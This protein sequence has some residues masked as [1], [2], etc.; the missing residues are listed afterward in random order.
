MPAIPDPEETIA[1]A[2]GEGMVAPGSPSITGS[3]TGEPSTL[4]HRYE[5]AADPNLEHFQD[6]AG[7]GVS[8]R[9]AMGAIDLAGPGDLTRKEIAAGVARPSAGDVVFGELLTAGPY[10]ALAYED[11][12]G[13]TTSTVGEFYQREAGRYYRPVTSSVGHEPAQITQSPTSTTNP[14]RPR[15][16]AAGWDNERRVMTVVFRDGTF[17]NYYGV[18]GLEWWNFIRSRSKGRALLATFD[19]KAR[20]Y[21]DVGGVPHAH[22][23]LLYK[24]AR[25][26]QV[27]KGGYTKG[28]KVGS[29][30]GTGG[31]YAYGAPGTSTSGGRAYARAKGAGRYL[32]K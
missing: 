13:P 26:G 6:D 4:F 27:I 10:Q 3:I 7:I 23:E 19:A 11:E 14:R 24:A 22:R 1:A 21:A 16:V 25:T 28:Q 30:R 12:F 5:R 2:K 20:G 32:G 18:S 17:Y 29:K 9:D 8:V 15:T 31:R